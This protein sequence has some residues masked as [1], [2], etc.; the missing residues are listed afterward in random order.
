MK[1]IKKY[2][3]LVSMILGPILHGFIQVDLAKITTIY[4]E[5]AC[6]ICGS[7]VKFSYS[8]NKTS[9]WQL[10]DYKNKPDIEFTCPEHPGK[11]IHKKSIGHN[12]LGMYTHTLLV[13]S[14]AFTIIFLIL[15]LLSPLYMYDRGRTVN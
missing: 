12:V 8:V 2:I 15:I 9:K 7:N 1:I 5:D 14:A 3:L 13:M 11:I 4:R 10:F 6:E